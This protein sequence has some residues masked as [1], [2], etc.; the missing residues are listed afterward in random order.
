MDTWQP[1]DIPV[2]RLTPDDG[3]YFF[4]YYDL[5][6]D[7]GRA[8]LCHKAP[9]MDRLHGPGDRVLVGTVPLNGGPFTPVDETGAWCFQQG[10][11]LQFLPG[12]DD[13]ILYNIETAGGY[14]ARVRSLAGGPVRDYDRPVT[15]LSPDGSF[16]LSVNMA[17]LYAFRPGYG[18]AGRPDPFAGEPAPA[19]D[20]VWRVDLPGGRARLLYSLADLA[21]L[22]GSTFAPGEKLCIN[23]ITVAPGGERCVLLLRN[24]E[25]HP[26]KTM[27]FTADCQGRGTPHVL[28]DEEMASH[29]WWQDAGHILFYAR[30]MG[31]DGLY[32][33]EDGCRR[34]QAWDEG[35]FAFDGHMRLSPDG[36]WL[37]YDRYPDEDGCRWLLLYH[38]AA[39]RGFRLARL[40]GPNPP[41][42]DIRC[43]LHPRWCQ[44]G[45]LLTID[46]IH[47]G[48][49]GVYALSA[50]DFPAL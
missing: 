6:A 11:M 46:S 37:S 9:F 23:H 39:G 19:E 10:A 30:V 42:I 32:T 29:Y 17:R 45:A 5:A 16:Y 48:F 35:L 49:R 50:A 20:G 4:G 15:A 14:G 34:A 3:H 31:K 24:M 7:N 28:L 40:F 21:A 22:S 26:W 2:R 27:V 43:D 44:D 8:H 41:I 25:Q 36:R 38:M 12:S 18:Y 33:L 47:E 1:C 13:R